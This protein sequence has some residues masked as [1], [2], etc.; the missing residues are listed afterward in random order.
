MTLPAGHPLPAD[1]YVFGNEI[2]QQVKSSKRAWEAA[3]LKAHGH[4]PAYPVTANLT[5]ESRA[6]LAAIDLHFPDLRREAGSRWLEGGVPLHTIRDWLGHTN[7]ARTS[8]YLAGTT[9][10]EHN[11][12]RH[13]EERRAT[14]AQL[15][16]DSRT[17]GRKRL[18]TVVRRERKPNKTAVGRTTAPRPGASPVRRGTFTTDC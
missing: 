14:L 17:G 18:Q 12:M 7:I 11:A 9:Q 2:G 3:V 6:A 4:T 5:A 13:F 15:G 1:A 8:T 10:T 16:T